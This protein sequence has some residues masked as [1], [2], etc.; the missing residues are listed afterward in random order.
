[1]PE[2]QAAIWQEAYDRFEKEYG[3]PAG[4]QPDDLSMLNFANDIEKFVYG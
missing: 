3:E 2:D 4:P 1:M